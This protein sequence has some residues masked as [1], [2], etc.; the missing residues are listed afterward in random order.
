MCDDVIKLDNYARGFVSSDSYKVLE[1]IKKEH[2]E[3]I[4]PQNL[5]LIGAG[6]APEMMGFLKIAVL[7]GNLYCSARVRP[8]SSGLTAGPAPQ[9]HVLLEA[10][11]TFTPVPLRFQQALIPE[12]MISREASLT[13]TS[14]PVRFLS[15]PIP[16][17]AILR[18]LHNALQQL[19]DERQRQDCTRLLTMLTLSHAPSNNDTSA[20]A[21]SN[22][23]CLIVV[24]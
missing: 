20:R 21:P 1:Y 4:I 24:P 5:C 6:P 7:R 22:V 8:G 19:A 18:T 16:E 14:V 11:F 15:V 12:T 17:T 23:F 10:S 3:I 2:P 13:F 9:M